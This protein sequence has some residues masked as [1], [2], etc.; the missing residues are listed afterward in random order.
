MSSEISVLSMEVVR[1]IIWFCYKLGDTQRVAHDKIKVAYGEDKVSLQT[2]YN[3][4]DHFARG[5]TA[6]SDKQRSGRP[7]IS[8]SVEAVSLVL[9]DQPYA[10]SYHISSETGLSKTTVLRI[11]HEDLKLHHFSLRW[12]PYALSPEQKIVRETVAQDLLAELDSMRPIGLSYVLTSDESW[13][14]HDNPHQAK[15]A[16]SRDEAGERARP[17]ITKEKTLIVVFWSFTGFSFVTSVPAGSTYTNDYLTNILIP[18][19]ETALR[20]FR[21]VLGIRRTKL[22]WDNARPHTAV[23]TKN[24]LA[25]RGV[26]LLPHPPY[27]PDLAPSDFFLF[28]YLKE[29]I[30][31]RNFLSSTELVDAIREILGG[32]STKTSLLEHSRSGR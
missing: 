32:E 30:R 14:C 29:L 8:E 25:S 2:V 27:S 1:G 16:L 11:L 12:V 19:L 6:V 4:Y 28:G 21:P 20:K 18:E 22:H 31:G 23:I 15:W 10:S 26:A 13:F 17:T 24:E 5:V 3:W 9:Q 7:R